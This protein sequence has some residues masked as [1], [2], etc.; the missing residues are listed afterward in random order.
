VSDEGSDR[1]ALAA[2]QQ[3]VAEQEQAAA[4]EAGAIGGATPDYGDEDP[5][6]RPLDEAGQGESEGFEQAEDEL[7]RSASHEDNLGTPGADAFP[8]EER[9][10]A[11]YG[12]ADEVRASEVSDEDPEG[13]N[14]AAR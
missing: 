6:T 4:E 10:G 14:P 3:R 5:A 13:A 11:T 7:I 9:S 12:E 2:E 1:D 8:D